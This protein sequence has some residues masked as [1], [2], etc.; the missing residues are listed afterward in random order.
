[1]ST[2]KQLRLRINGVK[3]TQKITKTMKMVAA[4]KLIKAQDK[5]ENAQNYANK[6][7]ATVMQL[8]GSILDYNETSALLTG[9][10]KDHTHLL[11]VVGSDKGLC[12]NYNGSLVKKLNSQIEV[13][14]SAHKRFKIICLGQKIFDQIKHLYG[15]FIIELLEGASSFKSSYEEAQRISTLIISLFEK[16]QFD[17]CSFIFNEFQNALSQSVCLKQLVPIN[18]GQSKKFEEEVSY[19]YEPNEAK[20]LE[21]LLPLNLTTQIYYILLESIASEH[22]A[23]MTAMEAAS[24]NAKDMIDNLTLIYNRSRQAAITKELIEIVSSAEVV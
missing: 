23:R 11:V 4:S 18:V 21:H 1:M 20:V 6:M 3:S 5:K 2:L 24:N 16:K 8:T 19:E 17:I 15:E 9:N 22:G 14:K 12:G 10:G 13:L 7:F